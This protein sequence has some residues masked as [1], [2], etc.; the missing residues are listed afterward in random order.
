MSGLSCNT[1]T[2]TCIGE[3]EKFHSGLLNIVVIRVLD[4]QKLRLLLMWNVPADKLILAQSQQFMTTN[5]TLFGISR[6]QF[7]QSAVTDHFTAAVSAF[8]SSV[9]PFHSYSIQVLSSTQVDVVGST[10]IGSVSDDQRHGVAAHA[11]MLLVIAMRIRFICRVPMA[12]L[13]AMGELS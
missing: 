1:E 5:L 11:R 3:W 8:L 10:C 12:R 13:Q 4:A 9:D 2:S 6:A 7:L